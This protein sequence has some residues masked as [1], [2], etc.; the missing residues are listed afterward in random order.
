MNVGEPSSDAAGELHI[1]RTSFFF[2]SATS[3]ASALASFLAVSFSSLLWA[4]TES[5]PS[6]AVKASAEIK[7]HRSLGSDLPH[8]PDGVVS[9]NERIRSLIDE[10]RQDS[11]LKRKTGAN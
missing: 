5:V 7:K 10:S 4:S 9:V 8:D 2:A 1:K 11:C 6:F 3:F